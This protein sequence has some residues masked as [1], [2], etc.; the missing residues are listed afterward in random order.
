M[1]LKERNVLLGAIYKNNNVNKERK[2]IIQNVLRK[3]KSQTRLCTFMDH[4]VKDI[5]AELVITS[6]FLCAGEKCRAIL[7]T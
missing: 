2:E 1:I 3:I 7:M 4:F 6:V 5:I